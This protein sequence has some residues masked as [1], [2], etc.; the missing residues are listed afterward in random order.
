MLDFAYVFDETLV[1][2]RSSPP[3]PPLRR[4]PVLGDLK[5]F[6]FDIEEADI[7]VLDHLNPEISMLVVV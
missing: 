4:C 2:L 3:L 1:I 6:A 7:A 5:A